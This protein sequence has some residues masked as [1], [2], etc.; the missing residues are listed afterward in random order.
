MYQN[1]CYY[2]SIF[3]LSNNK[4]IFKTEC[5]PDGEINFNGVGEC[6]FTFRRKYTFEHR[7]AWLEWY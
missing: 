3:N 7:C 6:H 2:V 1:E 5:L 4:E